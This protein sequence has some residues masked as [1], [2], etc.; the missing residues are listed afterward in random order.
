MISAIDTKSL[1]LILVCLGLLVVAPIFGQSLSS[2]NFNY[3]YDPNNEI[4]FV[5][6]PVVNNG[7]VQVYY[8]IIA[9]RKEFPVEVYTITWQSREDFNDRNEGVASGRDSVLTKSVQ[10]MDGIF[11]S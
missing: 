8:Q 2:M 3:C 5:M 9:N 1:R 6:S 10:V 7:R 4:N 11:T